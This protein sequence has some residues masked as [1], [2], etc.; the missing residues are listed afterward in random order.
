M[1]PRSAGKALFHLL[2]L[3]AVATAG[4][5][6]LTFYFSSSTIHSLLTENHQLNKAIRNLTHEEQIGYAKIESQG[7]NANGRMETV[8]RFVQT[9]VGNPKE[10]V[11]EQRF[12]VEGDILHFDALIVKFT[13]EYVRDGKE[14]ALYLWRR[15]YGEY[16]EPS[17]GAQIE[18]PDTA[19]DRYHAITRTLRLKDRDIFWEAIWGL[20]NDP[21]ALSSYG[22]KAVYGNVVYSRLRPGKV[23]LF[24]IGATGQIYP[25]VVADY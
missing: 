17:R 22:I 21:E 23:Y 5:L 12:T 2:A 13:D 11:S 1:I 8:I 9:A 16:T 15:V 18:I 7:H 25:E 19:P 3:G 4:V 24:R 10:I 6:A 20:A 14:R